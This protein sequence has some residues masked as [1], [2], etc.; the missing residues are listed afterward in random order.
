MSSITNNINLENTNNMKNNMET[1]TLY[2]LQGIFQSQLLSMELIKHDTRNKM[3]HMLKTHPQGNPE[4]T[5]EQILKLADDNKIK[6]V[7]GTNDP[8][9]YETYKREMNAMIRRIVIKHP[10]FFLSF[11]KTN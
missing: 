11:I 7:R 10:F 9:D 4:W 5:T 2:S 3:M 1:Q 6:W 8:T